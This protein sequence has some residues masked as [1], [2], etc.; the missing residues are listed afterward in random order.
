MSHEIE[1][2]VSPPF[3]RR[4]AYAYEPEGQAIG[5]MQA[6]AEGKLVSRVSIN[7]RFRVIVEEGLS[8]V[9]IND[10]KLLTLDCDLTLI[11]ELALRE[12]TVI[13]APSQVRPDIA[14]GRQEHLVAAVLVGEKVFYRSPGFNLARF[15]EQEAEIQKNGWP[16]L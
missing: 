7:S 8:W 3:K 16:K 11:P 10:E 13:S 4:A 5:V 1:L 9:V 6:Q 15:R 14:F 2:T 12:I